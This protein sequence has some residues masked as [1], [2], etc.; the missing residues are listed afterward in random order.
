MESKIKQNVMRRVH[1]IHTVRPYTSGIALAVVLLGI[2]LY[3]IGR[4]VFVAQ[5]FRNMPA[6]GDVSAVLRF[7]L[8]AFL[9]TELLVQVLTLVVCTAALWM[10]RDI[11]RL[12][13]GN[14]RMQL[15]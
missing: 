5:I 10:L 11:I 13:A 1:T 6:V 9:H 7:F 15:S 14:Q 2:S 4:F 3:A 8:S 12:M